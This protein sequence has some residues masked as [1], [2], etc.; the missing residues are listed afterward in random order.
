MPADRHRWAHPRRRRL[1]TAVVAA[2]GG[3]LRLRIVLLLA[4]VLALENADLATIGAVATGLK[5]DLAIS[6]SELGLAASASFVVGAAATIPA[7]ALADRVRRVDLLAG[8]IVLWA[9][10]MVATGAAPSLVWLLVSRLGLGA[11]TATAGPVLASLVG[12]YFPADERARM[13]G[14]IL[15]G[16]LLGGGVGF[17]V[18]GNVA[19][20]TSWRVPFFVLAVASA[21]LAWTIHRRLPEPARAGRTRI[22]AGADSMPAPSRRGDPGRGRSAEAETARR[23]VG[24][25]NIP[26]REELVL[27][28]APGRMSLA[29]VARYVL[30]IRTNVLLIV[31]SAVGYF[32][33]AG[34]RTFGVVFVSHHFGL[35]QGAAT[36]VLVVTGLGAVIGVVASG[37]L[38]DRLLERGMIDAR[39]VTAAVAFLAA[40][41]VLVPAVIVTSLVVAAPLMFVGGAALAF[42]N[43]PLDAARLDI[44]PSALWGRAE[45]VRTLL[46]N[47]AQAAAPLAFGVLADAFAG[48]R[49]SG[50]EFAFLIML[51]PLAL[52]GAIVYAGR[53][54]Y[55]T[56][57]ATAIESDA[58]L[59]RRR[60][61]QPA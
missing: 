53:R 38:S 50:I 16:E 15:S 19:A 22:P 61:R 60:Q 26:P 47:C 9:A 12:D 59:E 39:V 5:R 44:V 28:E 58:E 10:A 49:S 3:P 52:N 13:Y 4:A 23:I 32:F 48:P 18:S 31:A 41:V 14:Y 30:R 1:A 21:G 46:R 40:A 8:S 25:R 37:R 43:P 2:V 36:T 35:G 17:A 56:D 34:L 55:P 57:V 42:P 6:N 27:R 45:S 33:F 54:S 29:G 20:A 11:V 51:V 24:E 7:G